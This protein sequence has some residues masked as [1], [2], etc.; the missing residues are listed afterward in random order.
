MRFRG[1]ITAALAV[2][3]GLALSTHAAVPPGWIN[4][5]SA[6]AD[7]VFDVDT[8]TAVN[9]KHSALITSKPGAKGGGFGTLM[10]TIAADNYRGGRWRLSGY[11]RTESANRAQMWMRVDGANAKALG[12]DNMDSHPVVGT[13]GWTRYEI[14]LDVPPDSADIAFGFFLAGSG[15]VWGDGFRLEKVDATIPVTSAGPPMPRDPVNLDFEASNAAQTAVRTLEYAHG[16]APYVFDCDVPW[17]Q[18]K[19]LNIKAPA[20]KF[21]ITG[22]IRYLYTGG[23]PREWLPRATVTLVQKDQR[24]SVWLEG[25]VN[26]NITSFALEH[27][28]SWTSIFGEIESTGAAI[29]F[30]LTLDKSGKASS[31]VWRF[32]S[33]IVQTA[34]D[35]DHVTLS[36]STAHVRFTDVTIVALK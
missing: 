32:N 16:P 30:A 18:T 14:V 17:G 1:L 15:K 22:S 20:D 34:S 4:A 12:F 6:P 3:L 23:I 10:Q 26:R 35:I 5:G 13:T 27:G 33:P 36:C 9:G 7:Y 19:T 11:L 29:P 8:T 31:S 25:L 21:Q 24:P 28:E 2:G